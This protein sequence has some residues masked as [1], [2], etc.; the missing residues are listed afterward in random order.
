[1]S[2]TSTA[3]VSALLVLEACDRYL[4]ARQ[5]RVE[6]RIEAYVTRELAKPQGFFKRLLGVPKETREDILAQAKSIVAGYNWEG[7]YWVA[8]VESLRTLATVALQ[9]VGFAY[10]TLTVDDADLLEG[11]WE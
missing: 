11:Y 6:A 4:E 10:L 8:K 1:M 2:N 3:Q 7:G 5:K 9:Q